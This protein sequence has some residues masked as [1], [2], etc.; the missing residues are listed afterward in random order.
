MIGRLLFVALLILHCLLLPGFSKFMQSRPVEVKLGYVPHP[1][2]LKL[3][4]ADHQVLTAEAMVIK[5][6]FYFG[7][8]VEKF[9]QNVIIRPEQANMFRTLL[10][11]VKLD[12]YNVDA[13][14]FAQ[15]AFTWDVGRVAEV[16]ELL[17]W[18]VQ[19][20]TWDPWLPFYLGFNNAYF[21]KNYDLAAEYMQQAAEVSGNPLFTNLAAR[22]FYESA[23]TELGLVF[24]DAMIDTAKDKSVRQSYT[25]RR[26]SLLAI[27]KIEQAQSEFQETTGSSATELGD[28]LRT[29]LLTA[30]PADPYGGEFYL[31]EDG[32]VRSTSKL[33]PMK[34]D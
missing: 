8:L 23:Q 1:Q 18:G 17:K 16:N 15:A 30:I 2:A 22:Y 28:L 27:R 21:L 32:K 6:L 12:P 14:Y 25:L 13:Y 31:D 20:R 33:A 29:G 11:A 26:D 7:T 19:Y 10:T 24:L 34:G 4:T 9:D 5:V 3:A